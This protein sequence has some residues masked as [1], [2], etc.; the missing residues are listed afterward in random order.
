[1]AGLAVTIALYII[2]L[3]PGFFA[4]NDP[5]QQ[6]ARTAFHP[7]QALHLID[8][9]DDGGWSIRPYIHP[10]VLKRDP[11]T[12][13]SIYKEDRERKVYLHL[14]GEG[15]EYSVLGMFNA[16]THLFASE[17]ARQPLF[18]LRCRPARPLR[19]QPHHGGHPDFTLGRPG[20]RVSG[21]V[22][23]HCARRHFGLLRRAHRLCD[24]ARDR[25]GAVAADDSDLARDGGGLAAGL[26]G[27]AELLH[28]HRDPVAHRLGATRA[29]GTRPFPEPAHR[30]IRDGGAAGRRVRKSASS[31]AT[32]CPVSPATSSLRCR[33]RFRR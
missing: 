24:P 26:A 1:M 22:D 7:P 14:F 5:S 8:T 29:G 4:V 27:G 12:L 6:N 11:V 2:A 25:T 15:Y 32:C 17:N 3:V 19:V 31:F 18:F 30:R 16:R 28:D 13:A 21:A 23:R 20:R 9:A 33:S 10:Y